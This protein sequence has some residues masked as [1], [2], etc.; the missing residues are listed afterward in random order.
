MSDEKSRPYTPA[1]MTAQE[2][3]ELGTFFK[4]LIA[5]NPLIKASVIA[6]GI[7]GALEGLHIL[8]LALRFV[9]RF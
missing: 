5:E 4:Q 7:G 6:A 9:A 8:W 3:Q 1:R 2:F